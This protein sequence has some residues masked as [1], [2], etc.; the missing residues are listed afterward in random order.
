VPRGCVAI[1]FVSYIFKPE[2]ACKDA[3]SVH[4]DASLADCESS[5]TMAR[6]GC[7]GFTYNAERRDCYLKAACNVIEE[8]KSDV[9]GVLACLILLLRPLRM[10]RVWPAADSSCVVLQASRLC[11]HNAP[12]PQNDTF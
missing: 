11:R 4:R 8:E 5:C 7:V 1:G 2:T 3:H 12:R 6:D 10:R 9:T